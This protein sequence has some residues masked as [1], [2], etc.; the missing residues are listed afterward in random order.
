MAKNE[1]QQR[2]TTRKEYL[3]SRKQQEQYRQARLAIGALV[4]VLVLILAI[5]AIVEFVV[6]PRQ[7]AARVNEAEI[8]LG[9]W[10]DRVRFERAQTI[11]SIDALYEAVGQDVNQLQQ[12]ASTQLQQLLIPQFMGEQVL[13]AMID[14]ELI[15]QEADTLGISVSDAE[16]DASI[17]E[18]FN[19]Y[20]GELPPE[21]EAAETPVPT[22]TIT[23]IPAA[24]ATDVPEAEP[25]TEPEPAPEAT[26]VTQAS[27][28][29]SLQE[30]LDE[31]I[32]AGGTEETYRAR[33]E[34]SIL[35]E[36][37]RDAMVSDDELTTEELQVSFFYLSFQDAD[38]ANATQSQIAGG[39]DFL[40]VWNEIRSAERITATQPFASEFQFTSIQGITNSLGV[41]AGIAA[42]T[43]EIGEVSDVIAG[44]NDRFVVLQVRAR[45]DRPLSDA[46]IDTQRNE[47]V[48]TWLTEQR[49]AAQLFPRWEENVPDRPILDP[50]YYTAPEVPAETS[51]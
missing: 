17:E 34:L 4:G 9:D 10:Q 1:G 35:Q 5:G 31:W 18:R 30:Q 13:F 47:V 26:P 38:D 33:V 16:I 32:A 28:E 24:N 21:P 48:Q 22:P 11:S 12:F 25:T 43:L 46:R 41:E 27:Y 19:F 45:E 2:R 23:L 50:K 3:M 37:V 20:G 6:E 7:P 51:P 14:E 15:R 29:E 42:E 40:T 44:L 39:A 8:A 36:K 49:D